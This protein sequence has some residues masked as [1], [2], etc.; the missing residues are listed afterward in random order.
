MSRVIAENTTES[1]FAKAL[2]I[3]QD[4][5]ARVYQDAPIGLC[6]LDRE[7][8]Y[9]FINKWLAALNGKTIEQHL[10]NTMREVVPDI[11]IKVEVELQS[12]LDTGNPIF[13]GI[14]EVDNP[15]NPGEKIVF[16]HNY[17]AVYDGGKIIGVSCA[18]QDISEHVLASEL[19]REIEER[20]LNEQRL[21][22]NEKLFRNLLEAAPDA[23][24]FSDLEGTIK[25]VNQ[26]VE[27]LFGYS[28][29]EMLGQSN[30]ILLPERHR[31]AHRAH[32]HE[33][34]DSNDTPNI[35]VSRTMVC[36][37]KDGSEIPVEINLSVI[38]T[39][40]GVLVA[41]TIRD[42]SDRI[43]AEENLR[44]AR[45]ETAIQQE[46]L[47]RLV[48][49]QTLSEMASGIAH[50]ISQPLAAIQSYAMASNRYLSPHKLNSK[51]VTELL[52]KISTQALRAG[53]ILSHLR[54]MMQHRNLDFEPT[55]INAA[56]KEVTKLAEVDT[57]YHDCR[58]VLNFGPSLPKVNCDV[59]QIQQV[60]LNLVRNA[61]EAMEDLSEKF[62]KVVIIETRTLAT[63]LILI[64]VEDNGDGFNAEDKDLLFDAFYTTKT[65]GMGMGLSICKTI[66][67]AH[68]GQIS[69]IL[70]EKRGATFS[71]TLP[72]DTLGADLE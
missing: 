5:L 47:A 36:Q 61:M 56:L 45:Q 29:N 40:N 65:S 69:C 19:R 23:T 64:C 49:I 16:R 31:K 25:L 66:V 34:A 7:L 39:L 30:E 62:E 15:E 63:D 58:L 21:R 4:L 14:A 26:Q 55:D 46:R 67:K 17:T 43:Q 71:F 8:R 28:R 1:A 35:A 59:I 6:L 3:P 10:G 33:L 72:T 44:I 70:G 48:R 9:V 11:A 50:E 32:R 24:I 51:K 60:V 57:L 20:K 41:S 42:I 2:K 18:V 12:V 54:A 22:D 68:G 27:E 37:H 38:D 52:S 13:E 53:S